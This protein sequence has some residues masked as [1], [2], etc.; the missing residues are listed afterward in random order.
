M[1][2]ASRMT[3]TA[4]LRTALILLAFGVAAPAAAQTLAQTGAQSGAPAGQQHYDLN[5]YPAMNG[6]NPYDLNAASA[7]NGPPGTISMT[8]AAPTPAYSF[9][10]VLANTHGFLETGVSSRGGYEVSGGVSMPILPGKADLDLAAGTGQLAG[11]GKT[12]SGKT[13]LAVYDT[14]SAGLHIHPT[15]DTDAYIGI[16]GLRLHDL[17]PNPPFAFGLP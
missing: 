17:G 1:C 10:D 15:D 8:S 9:K 13:P 2:Y 5:V 4:S 7:Q 6:G 14:Y 16:S 12:P 11:W 3:T